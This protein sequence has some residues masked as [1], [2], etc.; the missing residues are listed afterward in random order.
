MKCDCPI[1]KD[2]EKLK[3][4][5]KK[6]GS[7]AKYYNSITVEEKQEHNRF[8]IKG[9]IQNRDDIASQAF[10]K[11]TNLNILSIEKLKKTLGLLSGEE[12]D[13]LS[14]ALYAPFI[15]KKIKSDPAEHWESEIVKNLME[16]R[17]EQEV[18]E[19]Q[20][21]EDDSNP[22]LDY[23]LLDIKRQIIHLMQYNEPI[24]IS[25]KVKGKAENTI[26]LSPK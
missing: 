19:E 15:H 24:K 7:L 14:D 16:K 9:I 3:Q 23:L 2:R 1:C 11:A 25:F 21:C 6:F 17:E 22:D 5:E 20:E 13:Q 10:I 18:D 8:F 12:A 26:S 4:G